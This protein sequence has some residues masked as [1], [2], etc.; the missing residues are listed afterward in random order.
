L[1]V[2]FLDKQWSICNLCNMSS[3]L[4]EK[5]ILVQI[6]EVTDPSEAEALARL[7]VDHI[8][9]VILSRD[10]WKLPRLK[11]TFDISKTGP[12]KSI[13]IPLFNKANSVFRALDYYRPDIV[14][15]CEALVGDSEEDIQRFI[16]LQEAVKKRFPDVGIM[17]S[18]PIAETGLADRVD[19]LELAKVFEPAS[20]Y[21]LTD[22]MLMKNG[23]F[24]FEH[25]PVGNFVGITGKICDWVM[26]AKLASSSSI[27]VILA[28]GIS[29]ENVFDGILKVKPAGIDS[30]TLTNAL[31]DNG[32][33]IRFK[34][35]IEK[36]RRLIAEVRRAEKER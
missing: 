31:D 36:V 27:P 12:S 13:L 17:R 29:P 5:R 23:E 8:G 35:D 11:E 18:I 19:T 25:Q 24:S 21:F 6:Y 3:V 4:P 9:S 26:A 10:D 16:E 7:G 22:T 30:C 32:R 2:G 14:H 33:P 15:F 20:D 28:G 34:K 1:S